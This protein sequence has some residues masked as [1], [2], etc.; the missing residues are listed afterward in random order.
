MNLKDILHGLVTRAAFASEVEREAFHAAVDNLDS[1]T[2]EESTES[3]AQNDAGV[4][5]ASE[6][7]T[8][9]PE[10]QTATPTTPPESSAGSTDGS[11]TGDNTEPGSVSPPEAQ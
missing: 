2:G 5:T 1:A 7:Q 6:A 3:A 9:A 4:G 8:V 10:G 11:Q